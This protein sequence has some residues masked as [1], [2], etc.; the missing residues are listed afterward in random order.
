MEILIRFF[1]GFC[2]GMVV[3]YVFQWVAE[4]SGWTER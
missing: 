2:I 4:I 3:L 1:I